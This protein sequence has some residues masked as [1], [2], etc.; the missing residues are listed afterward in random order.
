MWA[1][2]W[3]SHDLFILMRSFSFSFEHCDGACVR[4]FDLQ[5]RKLPVSMAVCCLPAF[6]A[7][8]SMRLS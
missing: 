6:R 1:Y 8:W 2:W 3:R 7:L 5:R 4:A